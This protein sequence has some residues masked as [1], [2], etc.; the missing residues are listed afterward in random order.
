MTNAQIKNVAK[1]HDDLV[2]VPNEFL[3]GFPDEIDMKSRRSETFAITISVET[4]LTLVCGPLPN[5]EGV[6]VRQIINFRE[7]AWNHIA[8]ESFGTFYTQEFKWANRILAWKEEYPDDVDIRVINPDG[9]MVVHLPLSWFRIKPP[10]RM[11]EEQKAK[12]A[13]RLATYRESRE[14]EQ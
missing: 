11:S 1:L 5:P 14:T 10:R 12:L 9:S 3:M 4:L 6:G 7:T 13:A 2:G 8:G